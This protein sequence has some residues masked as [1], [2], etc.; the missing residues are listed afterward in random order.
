MWWCFPAFKKTKK[1]KNQKLNLARVRPDR[2][3]SLSQAWKVLHLFSWKRSHAQQPNAETLKT[4]KLGVQNKRP[5]HLQSAIA[6]VLHLFTDF[7]YLRESFQM[8][9]T[10]TQL[11]KT[12][13]PSQN[14]MQ[15]FTYSWLNRWFQPRAAGSSDWRDLPYPGLRVCTATHHTVKYWWG[16]TGKNFTRQIEALSPNSQV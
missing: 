12:Q 4:V 14:K 15:L 10:R 7:F 1:Q 9:H 3:M 11:R 2:F 5:H 13:F 6:R 8:T 16:P